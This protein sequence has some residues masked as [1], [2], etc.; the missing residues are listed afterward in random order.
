MAL[1]DYTNRAYDYL[2]LRNTTG[3]GNRRLGMELFNDTT[4]GEICAGA[5][6]LAQRWLLEFMTERGSIPGLPK[7]GPN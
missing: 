7:R 1:S 5:Q 4:S 2:A 3:A 6:K